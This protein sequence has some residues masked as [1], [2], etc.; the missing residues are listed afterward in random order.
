MLKLIIALLLI[1][2]VAYSNPLELACEDVGGKIKRTYVCPKSKIFLPMKTCE[3][4]PADNITRFFNGCSSITGGH[5]D[6]F[7][8]A[9]ILHDLCYHHEPATNGMSRKEC[10]REFYTN[11]RQACNDSARNIKKCKR[12]AKFLYRGVRTV[13]WAAYHCANDKAPY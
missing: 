3:F 2:H 7:T 5:R 6:I 11:L 8:P 1:N 10:D 13:G 9:C 4:T 12:W